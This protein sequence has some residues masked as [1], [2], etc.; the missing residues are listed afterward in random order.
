MI[1]CIFCKIVRGNLSSFKV[2]EDGKNL[3]FLTIR[4]FKRGHSLVVPKKH[5]DYFFDLEEKD[6]ASL[7]LFCKKV[8]TILKKAFSPSSG[9]IGVVIG[10][11]EVAHVHVH[12][13][14]FDS[15]FDLSY[16]N[17]KAAS[18]EQLSEV[19]EKIRLVL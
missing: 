14:P 11:E 2:L 1:D 13:I 4:P 16:A 19:L 7:M 5:L 3:A 6:L 18:E 10:G 15:V 9:K 17:A 8:A 12:L